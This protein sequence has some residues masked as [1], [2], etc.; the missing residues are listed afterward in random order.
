MQM[1][2]T[3]LSLL[4]CL[5]KLTNGIPCNAKD[6]EL[7]NAVNDFRESKGENVTKIKILS[8]WSLTLSLLSLSYCIILCLFY[9]LFSLLYWYFSPLYSLFIVILIFL[10]SIFSFRSF[11]I[12]R[13]IS[14]SNKRYVNKSGTFTWRTSRSWKQGLQHA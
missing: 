1:M 14:Y 8:L 9:I 11:I 7:S 13:I 3:V 10:F 5:F 6:I 12:Y 2:T 4:F